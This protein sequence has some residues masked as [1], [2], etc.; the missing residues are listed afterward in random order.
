MSGDVPAVAWR[1][2]EVSF[3]DAHCAVRDLNLLQG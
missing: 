2:L 3:G 1:G